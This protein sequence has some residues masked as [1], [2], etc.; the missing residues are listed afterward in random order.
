MYDRSRPS[1]G[2]CIRRLTGLF[3]GD[4][5]SVLSRHSSKACHHS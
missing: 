1:G 5:A 2:G 3:G 4:F